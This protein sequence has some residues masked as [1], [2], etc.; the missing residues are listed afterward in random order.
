[1]KAIT[2]FP[3][4]GSLIH[5]SFV[6]SASALA[7][8]I[9]WPFCRSICPYCHFN[10]VLM[11]QVDEERWRKAF[12]QE[13][14]YWASR[15]GHNRNVTSIFFGGGT[16]SL[17]KESMVEALVDKIARTWF[18]SEGV[19]ITLEMNPTDAEKIPSFCHAGIR[20]ISLGVQSFH[21]ETLA[22]LGRTHSLTQLVQA[23]T[24]VQKADIRYS[25]DLI[26]GH[27]HHQE[28]DQW[29]QELAQAIP[30]LQG[31]LSLYQLTYEKGTPFY[32]KRKQELS[33]ER[34]LQ[35][36]QETA[37]ALSP[38]G[39][40]R[41]EISNYARPGEESLHNLAYW[42]YDD[43]L[44]L[45]PGAHGRITQK[46]RKRELR[47]AQSPQQWIT[48]VEAQGNAL[49]VDRVLSMEESL[50]ELL[51]MGLR[52]HKGIPLARLSS[53]PI[54]PSFFQRWTLCQQEQLM[55]TSNYHLVLTY[56]G[57]CVLDSVVEYLCSQDLVLDPSKI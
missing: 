14:D 55:E 18:L 19:E 20:R 9:H 47:S 48:H 17:M 2:E 8:Y 54:A 32:R 40:Y 36:E 5:P 49:E 25:M 44:G 57:S 30:W 39:L 52:L 10:R 53:Y 31:H 1:M 27:Q 35:L 34:L 29:Q 51:L 38:L 23:L 42:K 22:F 28:G 13:I 26:Y 7:I 21:K 46:S 6:T 33:Q 45:G 50:Q 11:T 15:I 41:Y 43:F 12:F 3:I 16:P 56:R 4:D 37:D 24:I